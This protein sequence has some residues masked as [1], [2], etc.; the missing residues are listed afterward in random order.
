MK[1]G[2]RLVTYHEGI[3]GYIV[4]CSSIPDMVGAGSER[5]KSRFPKNTCYVNGGSAIE[6]YVN[7]CYQL[8]YGRVV[9]SELVP[10][11]LCI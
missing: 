5:S 6:C 9:K 1:R 3:R 7:L 11:K 8:E 4:S 2:C 10:T